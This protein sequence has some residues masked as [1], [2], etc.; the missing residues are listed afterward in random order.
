ML[1][2]SLPHPT[3]FV[4]VTSQ[5]DPIIQMRLLQN[6]L[7]MVLDR[8]LRYAQVNRNIAVGQPSAT[9]PNISFPVPLMDYCLGPAC[10]LRKFL[11]YTES[12]LSG[13]RRFV[14]GNGLEVLVP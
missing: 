2:L 12:E 7:Q 9:S 10:H 4:G 13:H 14:Y 1:T 11:Q 8:I 6:I 3:L 5:L